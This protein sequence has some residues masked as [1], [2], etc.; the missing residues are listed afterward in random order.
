MRVH[1]ATH[2]CRPEGRVDDLCGE[3]PLVVGLL[4]RDEGRVRWDEEVMRS[5]RADERPND[6]GG[7]Q[8]RQVDADVELRLGAVVDGRQALEQARDRTGAS[9]V[10]VRVLADVVARPA[11]GFLAAR[12]AWR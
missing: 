1:L 7:L 12:G 8:G 6:G 5:D 11:F 2:R 10:D 9:A 3:K 4:G